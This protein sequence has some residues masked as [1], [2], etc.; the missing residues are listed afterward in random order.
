MRAPIIS[1]LLILFWYPFG[2][3]QTTKRDFAGRWVM[4]SPQ[5]GTE[6]VVKQDSATLTSGRLI[7]STVRSSRS[8]SMELK[9]VMS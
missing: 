8:S 3:A 2:G 5:V 9:R 4:I 6:L 7:H 1:V